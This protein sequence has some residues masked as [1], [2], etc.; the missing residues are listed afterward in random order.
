MT[1]RA[2]LVLAIPSIASAMLNHFYRVVDQ[3]F[4]QWIGVDAQAAVG[5]CTFVLIALYSLSVIL[6][7]G[8]SPLFARAVGANDIHRQRVILK[9]ALRI[10]IWI[11]MIFCLT[12][13][14]GAPMLAHA[15]GLTGTANQAMV[16]YLFALGMSGALIPLGPLVDGLFI[17]SGDTKTPMLLQLS[18]TVLNAGLNALMIFEL[19]LGLTGVAYASGISRALCT[20]TGLFLM[21]RRFGLG[22]SERLIQLKTIKIG[23]PVSAGVLMYALVYWGLLRWTISPLG[24]AVNAALGIGFSALEGVS[25]P[26]FSGV[27][28]ATSSIIGRALG[29]N[30]IEKVN[31][32]IRVAAPISMVLG[33][34]CALIFFFF[35]EAFCALFTQDPAVLKE[36][37]CYAKVLAFSQLFVAFEALSEGILSGAGDNRYQLWLS[38]PLNCIRIPLGYYFAVYYGWGA[39]GVWWAINIS[40]YTKVLGKWIWIWKGDWRTRPL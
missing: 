32:C 23:A 30:D 15:V 28:M 38:L 35:G 26:M 20:G 25:W 18:S 37:T 34:S 31:Q 14:L 39:A 13:I 10:S 1:H 6:S 16:D 4:V 27:M 8:A 9:S 29:A 21:T 22:D 12:L 11:S 40:T 5:A 33:S 36:A 7:A 17:A 2:L 3:Y 19:D 24:P